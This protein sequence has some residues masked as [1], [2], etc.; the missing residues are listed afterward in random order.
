MIERIVGFFRSL[1]GYNR[2]FWIANLSELLER[3]AFYGSSAML[4]IYMTKVRGI[5]ETAAYKLNGNLG[6]LVYGL[7]VLSGFVAD[8]LGYRRALMLAYGLLTAGYFLV[9]QMTT[10]WTI[11]GAL[12]LVALG[13][14]LIKPTITGTV[15]KTSSEPQRALGFS[16]YYML[17]NIGGMVGNAMGGQIANRAS[18]PSVYL[19][20]AGAVAGA[21]LLVVLLFREP[22]SEVA[23]ERKSLASFGRDFLGV[24]GNWR[25]DALFLCAAGFW[26]LFFLLYGPLAL[27]VTKDIGASEA[28]YGALL[29]I[30]SFAVVCCQ[31]IVGYLTSKMVPARAVLL[32]VV[33]ASG[34]MA[35]FGVAPSVYAVAAGILAVAAGEMVYSAHFYKYLGNLAPPDKVGMYM[36]FAFLPIALGS[37]FA[38][39]LGAL[40]TPYFRE[41]L[42]R[43]Q[44]M[45]FA[46]AA[47]GVV[48]AVGIALLTALSRDRRG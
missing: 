46:Y 28:T 40:L 13:A 8:L 20:C 41:T 3:T 27:Y 16:I 45:W 6:M 42:G 25:L 2:P 44:L 33:L 38:G 22:P 30:D 36:G 12:L 35:L 17:V 26:S 14:S 18:V 34:G 24:V 5:D 15:Q 9:G 4:V 23:A 29:S 43:P 39:Q 1:T 7:P 21:L 10:Y 11:A 37:F 48:A 32:G 19:V 47:V 31:V